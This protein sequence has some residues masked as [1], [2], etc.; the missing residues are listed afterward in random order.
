M[1]KTGLADGA[2]QLISNAKPAQLVDPSEK[3]LTVKAP[4]VE[5]T[6]GTTKVPQENPVPCAIPPHNIV[7]V[8]PEP[9]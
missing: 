1:A 9:S 3:N 7:P 5:V 6:T 4:V 2:T 8:V